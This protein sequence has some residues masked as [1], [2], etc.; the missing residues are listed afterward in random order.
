MCVCTHLSFL[1]FF[2]PRLSLSVFFIMPYCGAGSLLG[3]SPPAPARGAFLRWTTLLFHIRWIY[4]FI[5]LP[6][7][8]AHDT[9]DK[10]PRTQTLSH[11]AKEYAADRELLGLDPLCK[12]D[13]FCEVCDAAQEICLTCK[14]GYMVDTSTGGCVDAKLLRSDASQGGA[15]GG[16]YPAC[17]FGRKLEVDKETG[18]SECVLHMTL[19]I[20][21]SAVIF[22]VVLPLILFACGCMNCGQREKKL[23][24]LGYEDWVTRNEQTDLERGKQDDELDIANAMNTSYL[25]SSQVV[26][27]RLSHR[28][29]H[30]AGS[31]Y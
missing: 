3:L 23:T 2:N 30:N 24:P 10:E 29:S 7:V 4:V 1:S 9:P 20:Y 19:V 13:E 21:Y 25:R 14:S 11:T 22:A 31:L 27:P 17:P 8:G 15:E 12:D 18:R 16:K 28:T 6:S 5:A 26:A